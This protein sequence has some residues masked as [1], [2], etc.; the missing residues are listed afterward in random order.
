[1]AQILLNFD[2]NLIN[3]VLSDENSAKI[4]GKIVPSHICQKYVIHWQKNCSERLPPT[5]A[6]CR[7]LLSQIPQPTL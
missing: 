3:P 6:L 4:E 5:T 1:M 2:P 7:V